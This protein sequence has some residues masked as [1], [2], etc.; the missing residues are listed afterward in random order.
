MVNLESQSSMPLSATVAMTMRA[1]VSATLS[2]ALAQH[3]R[4]LE[5]MVVSAAVSQ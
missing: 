5:R 4:H 3:W 1:S 2:L